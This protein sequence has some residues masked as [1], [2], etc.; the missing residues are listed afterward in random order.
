MSYVSTEALAVLLSRYF[1]VGRTFHHPSIPGQLIYPIAEIDPDENPP[2]KRRRFG[3]TRAELLR[4]ILACLGRYGP[5]QHPVW[6]VRA[7]VA[8][9]LKV[10]DSVV[11]RALAELRHDRPPGSPRLA[12]LSDFVGALPPSASP[13]IVGREVFYQIAVL[14]PLPEDAASARA[15]S[16]SGQAISSAK[17]SERM[18]STRGAP[19][20]TTSVPRFLPHMRLST[21]CRSLRFTRLFSSMSFS[22]RS[23]PMGPQC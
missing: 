9:A 2:I 13:L 18:P 16:E 12:F 10:S 3:E 8:Y 21:N 20:G 23:V 11:D 14:L 17:T 6:K 19:T 1:V 15:T 7:E 5:G 4:E 22:C